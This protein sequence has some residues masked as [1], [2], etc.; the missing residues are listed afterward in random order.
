MS[1][2]WFEH[3]VFVQRKGYKMKQIALILLG[4]FIA[5][6]A[7]S[8]C[9]DF[10]GIEFSYCYGDFENTVIGTFCPD[11]PA[12]QSVM[13]SLTDGYMDTNDFLNI[14][15]GENTAAPQIGSITGE[16]TQNIFVSANASGCL[17][18]QVV[19][20]F[21]FSCTSPIPGQIWPEIAF[22]V[23]C[24]C[25]PPTSAF[26]VALEQ[27]CSD[28]ALNGAA[29]EMTLD[30]SAS[31]A[32]GGQTIVDYNWD[33]GDATSITSATPNITHDYSDP[34]GY[35][36]SLT[37]TDENGCESEI[38]QAFVEV[39]GQPEVLIVAP[40]AIC[41]DEDFNATGSVNNE[42]QWSPLPETVSSG[43]VND[44]INGQ[45][46]NAAVSTI[47]VDAPEGLLI[48]DVSQLVVSL[49]ISHTWFGDIGVYL[50]C[51][52][53][54]E[55]ALH[56]LIPWAG[57]NFDLTGCCYNFT[58]AA[59][60]TW[61]QAANGL[62]GNNLPT[63]DY[64]PSVNF[65]Q[66]IGCP[67]GGNWTLVVDESHPADD[68]VLHEWSIDFGA[69]G[70]PI[71]ANDFTVPINFDATAVWSGTGMNSDGSATAPSTPGD[72][73]YTVNYIDDYGCEYKETFEIEVLAANDVACV[74]P[75]QD[76]VF[77]ASDTTICDGGTVSLPDGSTEMPLGDKV[78]ENIF[79]GT[80]AAGCEVY[81]T[82]TVTVVFFPD[83][84][85]ETVS[86]CEDE[87]DFD[88]ASAD[89]TP[90][91][92][93]WYVGTDNTGTEL[94]GANLMQTG[95]SSGDQFYYEVDGGSGCTAGAVLNVFTVAA[96]ILDVMV[97]ACNG[98]MDY[99]I[100][101]LTGQDGA[102]YTITF[103]DPA[104][105]PFEVDGDSLYVFTIPNGTY[106]VSS[107]ESGTTNPD[108]PAV[109]AEFSG[110]ACSCPTVDSLFVESVPFCE[111]GML[112]DLS[113]Y[114][115]M[116]ALSDMVNITGFAWYSDAALTIET[117]DFS[118][119]GSGGD[120]APDTVT[121]YAGALC[122]SQPE[123]LAVGILHLVAYPDLSSTNVTVILEGECGPTI[124]VFDCD[125][126]DGIVLEND[127]D[128]NGSVPDYSMVDG[129]SQ[130]TFT[131]E[132][133]YISDALPG[134]P[135]SV[136]ELSVDY[137]CFTCPSMLMLSADAESV[138]SGTDVQ[139]IA[140]VTGEGATDYAWTGPDGW[141]TDE[142][143][144]LVNVTND[145][146]EPLVYSFNLVATCEGDG[147][148]VGD[149][150]INI[151]VYPTNLENFVTASGD[152]TC[153]TEIE[154]D[155]DCNGTLTADVL[156]QTANPGDGTGDHV[157]NLTYDDEGLNCSP[158]EITIEYNCPALTCFG[159]DFD[160]ANTASES[161]CGAF[162]P[163][164]LPV[165]GVGFVIDDPSTL[166]GSI[167]WY[168]DDNN[169][170]TMAYN[171]TGI[172]HS[173]ADDCAPDNVSLYAFAECDSNADGVGDSWIMVAQH[174]VVV[175]PD[176]QMPTISG[177]CTYTVTPICPDDVVDNPSFTFSP[178]TP[179]GTVDVTVSNINNPCSDEIFTL[180]YQECPSANCFSSDFDFTSPIMESV[181]TNSV[182]TSLPEEGSDFNIVDPT[183]L[184]G[185][186]AWY[187][188]S[189]TPPAQLYDGSALVHS[190]AD[191]CA[192]D[193]VTLYA[194]AECDTDADGVGNEWI[195]VAEHT[196]LIYP[197]M[198]TP[199]ISGQCD[200][201]ITPACPGDV[202][203]IDANFMLPPGSAAGVVDGIVS[204]PNNPCADLNFSLNYQECPSADC[205]SSDFNYNNL[206]I[207]RVCTGG[208]PANLPVEGIDFT[209]T[210]PMTFLDATLWYFDNNNP[211]TM[212]YDGSAFNHSGADNCAFE[213]ITLY[214]FGQCDTDSD[215]LVNDW[216]LV[217]QHEI[218]VYPQ[219]QTPTV[220]GQC[221]IVITPACPASDVLDNY[222]FSLSVGDPAGTVDVMVSDPINPC[223][224]QTFTLNYNEC[225]AADC[226]EINFTTGGSTAI[227]NN[228]IPSL[229]VEG[230]DF[231]IDDPTTLL[232]T[233]DWYFT[234]TDPP[235][236]PYDGSAIVHSDP[237]SC[238]PE[239]YNLFALGQCDNDL[240]GVG[241]SWIQIV[242][243]DVVVYPEFQEPTISG[244]CNIVITPACPDD[245]LDNTGFTLSP[246]DLAGSVDVVVSSAINPCSSVLFPLNYNE[247]PAL[248]CL[249]SDFD[250]NNT[251]TE[252]LCTGTAPLLP[253]A[254]TD[255]TITDTDNTLVGA[256]TW[257]FDNSAMPVNSYDG[258]NL[259]HSG[260]SN[261]DAEQISLFAYGQCDSDL[262]G[263]VD[264]W[265]LLAQH[266]V[267]L[268][269]EIQNPVISG[270]C[271]YTITV[272]CP[273]DVLDVPDTF[274]LD[275]SSPAGTI[276]V[277]VSNVNNACQDLMVQ[278]SYV[279]CPSAACF[280]S[281]FNFAAVQTESIC[282]QSA[283]TDFPIENTDFTIID[284]TTLVGNVTWY[285]DNNN[286]PVNEYNG[287]ILDN[288][289]AN[290]CA[291]TAYSFYAYGQ[292]D[293]DLDGTGDEWILVAEHQVMVYPEIQT[294]TISGQC[295]YTITP[296]CPGDVI[297][298]PDTF[299][300]T[301]GAAAGTQDVIVSNPD[302][303]C[304]DELFAVAYDA[305]PNA[306][307]LTSDFDFGNVF[308]ISLCNDDIPTL[309]ALGIDYNIDDPQSTAV[310][311][312]VVWFE[313]DDPLTS[314]VFVPGPIAHSEVDNCN[315][316]AANTIYAYLECDNNGDG[317]AD[318]WIKVA[319]YTYQVYPEIQ[320]P[321]IVGPSIDA[322]G[323][324]TFTI[325]PACPNDEIS[326][327]D[328][329]VSP[330]D[331][332]LGNVAV[333][334]TVNSAGF[335]P[336][337]IGD[338]TL[339]Y[340]ACPNLNCPNLA[341]V[342]PSS[343]LCN[344]SDVLDL[345]SL[346][347]TGI[348]AGVWSISDAPVGSTATLT[349]TVFDA[350]GIEPGVYEFTYT[351]DVV[352]PASC[353]QVAIQTVTVNE[354][355]T[356]DA[357]NDG[358][359][360]E[361]DNVSLSAMTVVGASYEWAGPGFTSMDQNPEITA[362]GTTGFGIYTLTVTLNGCV[363]TATTEVEAS[364]SGCTDP[365]ATNYDATAICDDGSC[366]FTDGC[367]D[368]IACNYNVNAT[369][370]DGS[371]DYG[372]ATCPD[373]CDAA[374]GCV[375]GT[376]CNF[377]A[378][379][380]CDDGSCIYGIVTCP[381]PCNDIVGCTDATACNYD[382]A[383][384]CDDGTCSAIA[385][386]DAGSAD[387]GCPEEEIFLLATAD[388]YTTS[389]W[390]GG[391]GYFVDVNVLE[392]SY[393]PADGEIGQVVL[394]LTV[395]GDC[396]SASDNVMVTIGDEDP[397]LNLDDYDVNI[398]EGEN[399]ISI[400]WSA[401]SFMGVATSVGLV[402]ELD[403]TW[404]LPVQNYVTGTYE[405][406]LTVTTVCGDLISDT[407]TINV[408]PFDTLD[409]GEDQSIISGE[410]VIL[411]VAADFN[412]QSF[413][414]SPDA[415]LDCDDCPNPVANPTETTTY[416]VSSNTLCPGVD[417]VTVNVEPVGGIFIPNAF[418]PN[419]DGIQDVYRVLG[420]GFELLSFKVFNRYGQLMFETNDVNDGWD[421]I[422]KTEYQEM[423]V[424][425][426][427]V[428]YIPNT[429]LV[430]KKLAG[431]VTLVR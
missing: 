179:A 236:M 222:G 106:T 398:C 89:A 214:G 332:P 68:G 363:A 357:S 174:N 300:L 17:T 407:L 364:V 205:F 247:C 117:A 311:L 304:A 192:A 118:V 267:T 328:E 354:M 287:E 422:Y 374:M 8:Q 245:V 286:P 264:E 113:S 84:M 213:P 19:S 110:P 337:S 315:P 252:I 285:Y 54:T 180:N 226:F 187:F 202:F 319:E 208:S 358:P 188:D 349:G 99:D 149:E 134:S 418:S 343:D 353:D 233:I 366:S 402:N 47:F 291:A 56:G 51:P 381:D 141:M 414:W 269:P 295:L 146:C 230:V 262:N 23:E 45:G 111:S 283:P 240:D 327:N 347:G 249:S 405:D 189:S 151:T 103:D 53:G 401:T 39:S 361:G 348:E 356:A 159:S 82:V 320:E 220:S 124:T 71:I 388:A 92:G 258:S 250:F 109:S 324:C 115:D 256:V 340:A 329:V 333:N 351:P 12:S 257:Y 184:V 426:Y 344:G 70:V 79:V 62:G 235:T 261:C 227:C 224:T 170:P 30:A 100:S 156:T 193:N 386:V 380:T 410:N 430:T 411:N 325:T 330:P 413:N 130:V 160:F 272:A 217:A 161:I 172:V 108:C 168:F 50:I 331:T 86:L 276:D 421:G 346:E 93:T 16:S 246:G 207:E 83:V 13:M 65:S 314:T 136:Y 85:V 275:P 289:D 400:D 371:C 263:T 165:E 302:N 290:N 6:P 41:P 28:E 171:G 404:D 38:V 297:D 206:M 167:D 298:V 173:G 253:E 163:L 31:S 301:P 369:V 64:R 336:C 152:G 384:T 52:D 20:D 372:V 139:L 310:N 339:N 58:M 341:T 373:P 33:F 198:Q 370:D 3:V 392:T 32:L 34:G 29:F 335:Y 203:D 420:S 355:P 5:I 393:F 424:Y 305:C 155:A 72:Y 365:I 140:N 243:F 66:L 60:E 409:A 147:T 274:T 2:Y 293:T 61:Q 280:D 59:G 323:N 69:D 22:E 279:E 186:I 412:I 77:I 396:G 80:D 178:N 265:I 210:N 11:D 244:Q 96:P 137:L 391:N 415:S 231:A 76:P 419:N 46:P 225:P 183:T 133:T 37:V 318:D 342:P 49:N 190:G 121:V 397:N 74:V 119:V 352:P 375:D 383:A 368:P 238:D 101:V 379:A 288:T 278:L 123:P 255:F 162:M 153:T 48:T 306:S 334:V 377:D 197:E 88:L 360:C 195:L 128:F 36:V 175:Y 223:A 385:V 201:T 282:N 154:I 248:A 182:P 14:F 317:V 376:A 281:D 138:C 15:D 271:T 309:P 75:C 24:V 316:D 204:N 169:P 196:V 313:D 200:Y 67:I 9:S 18:I 303:P 7:F 78:F 102:T 307:C 378:A 73:T 237:T 395:T 382:P 42:Y 403:Q 431:N 296:A 10:E 312:D 277:V 116:S 209:L 239:T 191:N 25:A 228:T 21:I 81:E 234:N 185:G 150:T 259:Q 425:S 417:S 126:V 27:L 148:E 97:E 423:G 321:T 389:T 122:S 394:T 387:P 326:G 44:I 164:A 284:P 221:D 114:E 254:G 229:P 90:I 427:F 98:D 429:E 135:C 129:M 158:T 181:C 268:Y 127:L 294:P 107:N 367:T 199:S 218:A 112:N 292:C 399:Q 345:T 145:G 416:I 87:A 219:L 91:G 26:S 194:F 251:A 338:F 232:G 408:L 212:P 242:A 1:I 270:Q 40:T 260:A 308:T 215:G 63:G 4:F 362:I 95:L 406:Y 390:S 55:I 241:D 144:P 266:D 166:V 94:T 359:V 104:V 350:T 428:E 143:N 131:F 57:F 211:P 176:Y 273:D 216:I 142:K 132:Q 125:G 322:D 35:I 43:N 157:Y 105:G 299:T 120:C 177:Q